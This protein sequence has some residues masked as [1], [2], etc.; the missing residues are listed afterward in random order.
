MRVG[1]IVFATMA[2]LLSIVTADSLSK[3][4]LTITSPSSKDTLDGVYIKSG[5]INRS[6]LEEDSVS[7]GKEE[8]AAA[9][10]VNT[11]TVTKLKT[12]LKTA[13]NDFLWHFFRALVPERFRKV[14]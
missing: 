5:Q 3:E 14:P 1:F 8:R 7:D 9:V 11:G 10:P 12:K 6:S 4:K 13:K 2:A